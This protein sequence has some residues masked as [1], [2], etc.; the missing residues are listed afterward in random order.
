ML[1]RYK[2]FKVSVGPSTETNAC[3]NSSKQPRQLA[4]SK[5]TAI[6]KIAW[7]HFAVSFCFNMFQLFQRGHTHSM[8]D[9]KNDFCRSKR[10]HFFQIQQIRWWSFMYQLADLFT[11]KHS[12][13]TPRSVSKLPE[14]L[15]CFTPSNAAFCSSTWRMLDTPAV[16]FV[17]SKAECN[18]NQT[19][20][21]VCSRLPSAIFSALCY[22]FLHASL[23]HLIFMVMTSNDM[24]TWPDMT[25]YRSSNHASM[26]EECRDKT[27]R[28]SSKRF[29]TKASWKS[30]NLV[31]ICTDLY[32]TC[33]PFWQCWIPARTAS[34]LSALSQMT[35]ADANILGHHT[36]M[37]L[38]QRLEVVISE[39]P[40]LEATKRCQNPVE[41]FGTDG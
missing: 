26:G 22:Q 1:P 25:I 28:L 3:V 29:L 13:F 12:A 19:G 39:A 15:M 21:H 7:S 24:M 36:I 30:G 33:W 38:E 16:N 17:Y 37:C 9:F 6:D 8:L 5:E 18:T 41:A 2:V 27:Q 34:R 10:F 11:L 20:G 14:R 35:L 23:M 40:I 31:G 32:A 4:E